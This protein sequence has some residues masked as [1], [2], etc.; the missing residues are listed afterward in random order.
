[1]AEKAKTATGKKVK[2]RLERIPG[3]LTEDVIIGI[4]GVN[5]QIPRGREVELPDFVYAE[6]ERSRRASEKLLDR[7]EDMKYADP[8]KAQSVAEL[9]QASA[10]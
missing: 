6:Y 1:M 5:Y 8:V 9:L 10:N 4:N 2:V 3:L 7:Q